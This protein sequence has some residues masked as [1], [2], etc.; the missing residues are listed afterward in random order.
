MRR[1][2]LRSGVAL[3]AVSLLP[4]VSQ[5]A[6]A[7]PRRLRSGTRVRICMDSVVA[8]F[9]ISRQRSRL[10]RRRRRVAVA[11]G[12]RA[13]P[14][15]REQGEC[16]RGDAALHRCQNKNTMEGRVPR[17]S[18]WVSVG[19]VSPTGSC[20]TP[21][22]AK[23]EVGGREGSW[24]PSSM[25]HRFTLPSSKRRRSSSSAADLCGRL[26]AEPSPTE[27]AAAR[28]PSARGVLASDPRRWAIPAAAA[29]PPTKPQPSHSQQ[30][31][32]LGRRFVC[33]APPVEPSS[34]A[35][36]PPHAFAEPAEDIEEISEDEIED[37]GQLASSAANDHDLWPACATSPYQVAATP[38]RP[39]RWQTRLARRNKGRRIAVR[40]WNCL[41]GVC[42]G[43]GRQT[44]APT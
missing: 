41:A 12:A 42:N 18:V 29:P 21:R 3:R 10:R 16:A 44:V 31:L 17:L 37:E 36:L 8:V 13:R 7:G 26:P 20:S 38:L 4:A 15:R 30:P 23:Q 5:R 9:G 6:G 40:S 39:W 11:V 32:S 14:L 33:P 22:Y 43:S 1:L 35:A 28:A 2:W 24:R 19:G 25:A 27:A 34:S